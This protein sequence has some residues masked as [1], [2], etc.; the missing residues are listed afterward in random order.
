MAERPIL[1]TERLVLRPFLLS[2]AHD[3]Q[4]LAGDRAIAETTLNIPHPYGDGLAEEWISKH[5]DLFD[6]GKALHFAITLK[7]DQELVGAV[8]LMSMVKGHQAELGYWI[9]KPYW[10]QGYCT[11]AA[12]EVVRY[13]FD[14]LGLN[15]IHAC[16]FSR[17]AASGSI[18][19]KLGMTHEGHRRQH[20]IKWGVFDDMD[21]YGILRSEWEKSG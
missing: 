6:Q 18:M 7:G 11:E 2:D 20:V 14:I 21:L 1:E 5:Q 3:V 8:S 17:N 15:R 16:H 10:N 9:G 13:G 4:Q 19:L 12:R